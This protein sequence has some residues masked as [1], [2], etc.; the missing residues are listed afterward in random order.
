MYYFSDKKSNKIRINNIPS[1]FL[2][3]TRNGDILKVTKLRE[4]F[5]VAV[6]VK[7]KDQLV[8]NNVEKSIYL[9]FEDMLQIGTATF[10]WKEKMVE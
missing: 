4:E 10:T 6:K 2:S 1:K 8:F 3:L 7:K 5:S 9:Y